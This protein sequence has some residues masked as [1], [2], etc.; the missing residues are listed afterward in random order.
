MNWIARRGGWTALAVG[1]AALW[2]AHHVA[3]QLH[4]PVRLTRIYSGS[5]GQSHAEEVDVALLPRA[6][7]AGYAQSEAVRAASLQVVRAAP[8]YVAD[9]HAA[10]ERQ[11]LITISGH[12]EIEVTGGRKIPMEPGRILLVEDVT[13]KGHL[14]RTVG[15]EDRVSVIV[16]VAGP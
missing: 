11:Y 3:A 15:T 9:W 16:P 1:L 10:P 13:G 8:G 4:K 12:G 14:T 7:R 2:S 5:D 6:G